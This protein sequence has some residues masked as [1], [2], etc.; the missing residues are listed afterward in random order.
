LRACVANL[1]EDVAGFKVKNE[2]VGSALKGEG[3]GEDMMMGVAAGTDF[4]GVEIGC[5]P[6]MV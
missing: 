6:T 5:E 1:L 3:A 4:R 2:E